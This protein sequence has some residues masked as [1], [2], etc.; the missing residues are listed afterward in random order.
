MLSLTGFLL[1]LQITLREICELK[2][3][4]LNLKQ[5]FLTC[6]LESTQCPDKEIPKTIF[7]HRFFFLVF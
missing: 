2:E 7:R 3:T 6:L 1:E 5:N 4:N